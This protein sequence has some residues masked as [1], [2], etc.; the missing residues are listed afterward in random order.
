MPEQGLPGIG[1]E[2]H[3]PRPVAA[4][5]VQ[6]ARRL[7]IRSPG[8]FRSRACC[9][10]RRRC[11]RSRRC[12]SRRC[13]SRR[14]RSRDCR[15][16]SAKKDSLVRCY[17]AAFLNAFTF[18]EGQ[19]A[20]GTILDTPAS[21]HACLGPI[22]L[23]T[24]PQGL[25]PFRCRLAY[26]QYSSPRIRPPLPGMAPFPPQRAQVAASQDAALRPLPVIGNGDIL[27]WR[28]HEERLEQ[29][30]ELY[31]AGEGEGVAGGDGGQGQQRWS[32]CC[33]LARS[34]SLAVAGSWKF[35]LILIPVRGVWSWSMSV[36]TSLSACFQHA[37]ACLEKRV[38]P[39]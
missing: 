3:D 14:C 36:V 31:Q 33:M 30:R 25:S 32:T 11:C 19:P 20:S 24:R 9:C 21:S 35:L 5:A 27:S 38:R 12:R 17:V 2:R 29:A 34:E 23:R 13:R 22:C 7:G 18:W 26:S 6:Q 10:G 15:C 4:S 39:N 8:A 16:S 1:G 28:D 37:F